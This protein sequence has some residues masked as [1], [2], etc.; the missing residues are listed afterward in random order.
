MRT[1]SPFPRGDLLTSVTSGSQETLVPAPALPLTA[2][3][4][5]V[6]KVIF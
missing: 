2:C 6:S 4:T 3:V 1:Q 5:L